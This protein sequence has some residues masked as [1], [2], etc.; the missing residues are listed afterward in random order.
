MNTSL[1]YVCKP[2][3]DLTTGEL[4]DLLALRAEVFVVEQD[5][6]YQDLDYKDQHSWHL[7]GIDPADGKLL[8]YTRLLPAGVSYPEYPA[9]GRVV[10]SPQARGQGLGI[11]LMRVSIAETR[12]L[13]GKGPIKLSAQK[14]LIRFYES[15]G[16]RQVGEE[17]LEDGIP[18]I[19]MIAPPQ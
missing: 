16:F 12:R 18:H 15:F 9:I 5:C 11:E 10:T 8:A 14:Y 6:P 7:L 1:Q 13:F 2:F 19:A 3:S 4:Y 17:Y